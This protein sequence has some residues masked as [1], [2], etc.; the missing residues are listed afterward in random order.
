[1]RAASCMHM[2]RRAYV[3]ARTRACVSACFGEVALLKRAPRNA[4][5]VAKGDLYVACIS[6]DAFEGALGHSLADMRLAH[7]EQD[8]L[9]LEKLG[10]AAPGVKPKAPAP[11]AATSALA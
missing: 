2:C 8:A 11:A 5:I 4:S 6:R 1:M 10:V 3:C 7:D 9:R